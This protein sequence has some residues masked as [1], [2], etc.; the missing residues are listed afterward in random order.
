MIKRSLP[1]VLGESERAFPTKKAKRVRLNS[2]LP[3]TNHLLSR[4]LQATP[5]A[6]EHLERVVVTPGPWPT[7]GEVDDEGYVNFLESGLI[8]LFWPAAQPV[9]S[10]GMALLG[11]NACWSSGG[12]GIS[13]LQ[14]RVLQAGHAQRIR[15]SVL[16]AQPQRYAAWL[17]Q[18]AE[19]SQQLMH[20]IAQMAFCA[21]NHKILQRM[22]SMLLMMQRNQH[23]QA[24]ISVTDLAQGLSCSEGQVRAAAQTLQAHGALMLQLDESVG[25][26]LHSL[27]PPLLASLACSC[28]LQLVHRQGA[29][30]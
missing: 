25:P 17:I 8:G 5:A 9:S 22:S 10:V 4:L 20:Q 6:A 11:C 23:C 26:K 27:Q 21:A 13:P 18:T 28:H 24:E 19:A 15:W 1:S 30:G 7:W 14:T 29:M 3:S 16:Q 12:S 2:M